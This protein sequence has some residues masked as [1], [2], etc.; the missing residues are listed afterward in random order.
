LAY[1]KNADEMDRIAMERASDGYPLTAI[2][3]HNRAS[4][5]RNQYPEDQGPPVIFVQNP[6][7]TPTVNNETGSSGSSVLP[8]LALLGAGL[9]L[10]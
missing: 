4:E 5:L 8:A 9:V 7:S 2:A 10:S 6:E 1:G 3:L